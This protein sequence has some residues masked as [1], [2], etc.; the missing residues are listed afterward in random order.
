MLLLRQHALCEP[1]ICYTGDLL[2]PDRPKYSFQYYV[3]MAKQL[4]RLGAHFLGIKDMAGLCKPYAAFQL[5]KAL[6]EEI[7]IPNSFPHP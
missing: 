4:E 2:N 5:V 7:G 1:A 3:K 6:R